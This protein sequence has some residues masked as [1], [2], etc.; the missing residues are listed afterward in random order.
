[1]PL[2]TFKFKIF[3]N[4]LPFPVLEIRAESYNEACDKVDDYLEDFGQSTVVSLLVNRFM[5]ET[6]ETTEMVTLIKT[7]LQLMEGNLTLKYTAG[8]V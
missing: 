5:A 1:M 6:V 8:I 3:K 4:R 7:R 2:E